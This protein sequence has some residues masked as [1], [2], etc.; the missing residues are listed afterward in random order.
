MPDLADATS[1]ALNVMPRTEQSYG[2]FS[3]LSSFGTTAL[4]GQCIGAVTTQMIDATVT[5]FAGTA[6]KL[7]RMAD[8]TVGFVDVSGTAYSIATGDTWHFELYGPK[9]FATNFADPIQSYTQGVSVTFSDLSA[10]APHARYLC[11]PK[12]FLMVANTFDAVGGTN[13][14][15]VWW[16]GSGDPTSWPAP[17]SAL[18][19]QEQS[20]FQDF[21]GSYGE[22]TGIFDSLASADVAIFFRQAVWRGLYVGP[23]DVFDFF[24]TENVRGSPYPNAFVPLGSVIYYPSDDGFYVFD[25]STS[26]PIGSQKFD[27][28][29]CTNMNQAFPWMVI[30]AA[31]VENRA[32]IWIFPSTASSS[33]IPD[34]ALI[35]RWDLQ[36]ASYC[37][38]SAEWLMRLL[39][40]GVTLDGFPA[41]G[42]PVLDTIPYSLDSR[43]WQGGALQIGAIDT[44]HKLAY[45]AGATMAA[46]IA[47]STVQIT[48]G[49]LSWVDSTRPLIQMTSLPS[50]V[51]IAV[52]GRNNQYDPIVYGPLVPPNSM[53]DCPQ[54]SDAR[55][56]SA[57]M[58]ISAGAA[59]SHAV[60]V[61]GNGQPSGER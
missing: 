3:S 58:A 57:M 17:G 35:Y 5:V 48:P 19:Q 36:R 41:A 20:D 55:Y 34:T 22:I 50:G 45:F 6:D 51:S 15:R 31:D 43:V 46:Q 37:K 56:H 11:T 10:D 23:P 1:L 26:T 9:V 7:Y 44:S 39:S 30:G 60:G 33:G 16:S 47:T 53:G 54:R 42:Y 29:F 21:Q 18:A 59:W 2:P 8:S 27:D 14:A 12:N 4:D 13:P 32:I 38:F 61:D 25:G 49:R 52:S 28:W 40:F 24:P